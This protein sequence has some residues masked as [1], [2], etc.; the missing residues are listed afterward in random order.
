MTSREAFNKIY[1]HAYYGIEMD[2]PE[3]LDWLEHRKNEVLK[4]LEI[5]E[6]LKKK[7]KIKSYYLGI[8]DIFIYEEDEEDY[9]K[10][11]EWLENDKI[12][13]NNN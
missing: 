1:D 4:D 11:R 10:I 6:I 2:A 13:E 7:L 12:S 8:E 3:L 5:L 9:E